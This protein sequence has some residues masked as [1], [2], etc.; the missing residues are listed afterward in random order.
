M[1]YPTA[2][3]RMTE[4]DAKDEPL[5]VH[6][7]TVFRYTV[8]L[9]FRSTASSV[10]LP[11]PRENWST[12]HHLLEALEVGKIALYPGIFSRHGKA[13]GIVDEPAAHHG[14]R[15]VGDPG[16]RQA[17]VLCQSPGFHPRPGQN[18]CEAGPWR[19]RFPD[20]WSPAG[21]QRRYPLHPKREA[22]AVRS[23]GPGAPR[24]GAPARTGRT[25]P[26]A[27]SRMRST[28]MDND[29]FHARPEYFQ[30]KLHSFFT[31]AVQTHAEGNSL[32]RLVNLRLR[33]GSAGRYR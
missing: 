17:A 22:S 5:P 26:A 4:K 15:L 16:D 19:R 2:S 30:E 25:A 18:S 1:L 33:S 12:N 20:P 13:E 24:C 31:S 6:G 32:L 7:A 10:V 29:A 9:S 27:C 28:P 21:R 14:V 8:R 23:G 11:P 3:T